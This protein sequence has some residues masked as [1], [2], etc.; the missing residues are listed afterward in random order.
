MPAAEFLAGTGYAGGDHYVDEPAVV[1]GD[2][3][4]ANSVAPVEFARA[5]LERLDVYEPGV[6][7]SWFKLFGQKDPAGFYELMEVS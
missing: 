6:L 3:V 5:I 1:D 2:L 7:A 4:T